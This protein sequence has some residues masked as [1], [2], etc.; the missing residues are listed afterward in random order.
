LAVMHFTSNA[1][2]A[3]QSKFVITAFAVPVA[4]PIAPFAPY[5]Y[6]VAD[7]QAEYA[8]VPKLRLP[9]PVESLG[10]ERRTP[11]RDRAAQEEPHRGVFPGGASQRERS[12]SGSSILSLRCSACHGRTSPKMG[13]SLVDLP[14]ISAEDRLR[15]IRAVLDGKMPPDDAEPLTEEDRAAILRELTD[16]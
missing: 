13:L 14:A 2:H 11:L 8:R 10:V 1:S 9:R 4:V 12:A 16:E 15:A 6:S 5:W 7:Y 3:T